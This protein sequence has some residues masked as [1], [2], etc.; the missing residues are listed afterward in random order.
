[1]GRPRI[2]SDEERREKQRANSAGYYRKHREEQLAYQKAYY[3]EYSDAAKKYAHE[4]YIEKLRARR[5]STPRPEYVYMC[6]ESPDSPVV[7]AEGRTMRELAEKIGCSTET[8]KSSL[9]H[10]RR[11]LIKSSRYLQIR[12]DE[13]D[14]DE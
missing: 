3:R 8:I 10:L 11:G 13:D 4:Y 2:Y 12:L 14:G 7:I 1:M 6:M 5:G 9:S